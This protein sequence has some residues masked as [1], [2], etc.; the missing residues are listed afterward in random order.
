MNSDLYN[1]IKDNYTGRLSIIFHRYHEAGKT[2]I[3]ETER[4]QD[5][6]LCEKIVGYDALYHWAVMQNMPTG[7]YTRRLAENEF[8]P[9]GSR[10]WR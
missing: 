6:K 1:L 4:G 5:A 3:R 9:K 2:K 8:K 10:R 7:R